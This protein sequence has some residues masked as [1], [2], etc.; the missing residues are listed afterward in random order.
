MRR[1]GR[2]SDVLLGCPLSQE[3]KTVKLF[4]LRQW[5][6]KDKALGLGAPDLGADSH[7]EE[8]QKSHPPRSNSSP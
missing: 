5:L 3:G 7:L 1:V 6:M 2:L 4:D 8:S